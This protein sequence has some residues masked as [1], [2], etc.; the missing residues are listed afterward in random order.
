MS[1]TKRIE[2][3]KSIIIMLLYLLVTEISW[4]ESFESGVK[5][6]VLIIQTTLNNQFT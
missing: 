1:K 2:S 3:A 6:I 5:D 4:A